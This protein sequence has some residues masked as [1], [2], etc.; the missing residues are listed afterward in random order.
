[1]NK[2]PGGDGPGVDSHRPLKRL[3]E[4]A[5]NDET[6]SISSEVDKDF[7]K[8]YSKLGYKRVF[9]DNSAGITGNE[10][11]DN[12]THNKPDEDHTQTCRVPYTDFNTYLTES[13]KLLWSNYWHHV[14][15]EKGKWYH[16]IQK[17]LPARPWYHPKQ[18]K[19]NLNRNLITTTCRMRFGHCKIPAHL[20]KIRIARDSKCIFCEEEGADLNHL[21]LKCRHQDYKLNRLLLK[22]HPNLKI[23]YD[24]LKSIDT[25]GRVATTQGGVSVEYD[26]ICLCTGGI[27]RLISQANKSQRVLGIR[28]TESVQELQKRLLNGRKMIIVGNG[29]IASEIVHATRGIQKVW[30]IRD[31]YISATFIDPGAAQFFQDTFNKK[32]EESAKNT[33]IRRHIFSEEDTLV[34]LNKDLKSAALGPDWYRKLEGIRNENGEQELEIIYKV[35]V[36]SLLEQESEYPLRVELSNGRIID[37]DFVISATGV[38][39]ALNFSWDKEPIKAPDG[40]IAVNEF[41]ETS[42]TN[43]FAAGDV[44]HAAWTHAP[45]WFQLRLWTQARQMAAMAAKSMH[46]RKNNEEVLQDFCFELFT[47]CTSLFG[48]RVV[49]LGKYNG[50]NLGH[51]YEILLRTTPQLEYI[52]FVLQNGKLQGAILIGETDLEEMCENLILDQIDL[53]PF[54]DRVAVIALHRCGYAPIQIFDILKNLNITKRFVYHTIKR[55][56]EDSSVDDRSRSGRPRS[57]RTPAVIKAVKARIQRNLKRKQKLLALRMGLSRTTV[58]RKNRTSFECSSHGPER[59]KRCRALLKRSEEASNRIPRVERGHFPS[60]L[61][62]WLGVSYWGLIGVHFCEKGVKTNAVVYQN[63]VLTNLVEPVSHTMFNNRHWVFQQ[64]SA[65]AHRAKS[66]QDWLSA[67]EIDFI[68]HE[69][70]PS[71]SPDLSPLDYKIWQHLE[72]KAC[73]KPHPNLESLKTPLIKAAADIDM[74][75]VPLDILLI[76]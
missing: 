7:Y 72:K 74:D 31:D 11:V 39:P 41:Q 70:W 60:S 4:T 69:D 62:V 35:E 10:V 55:Y 18:L 54:E 38:E 34:S 50:Q 43:V 52:K 57:V 22:I 20:H 29:G 37:C 65:P 42:I 14:A 12:V 46:A 48:Y 36:K 51:D 64:D 75:L 24:S 59:L 8:P 67:R 17:T 73:S 68:R 6:F 32:P 5:D 76:K 66:T 28:D 49:L 27:P 26:M 9:P 30:V 63:T 3:R 23:I 2:T 47:H 16:D 33:I 44:A 58:K 25:S 53:N 21:I 15:S 13:H 40:G 56:N 61:M 1:M 71:S 45:H 19:G